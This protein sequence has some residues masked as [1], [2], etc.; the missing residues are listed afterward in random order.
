MSKSWKCPRCSTANDTSSITCTSCGLLQGSVFVPS[1]LDD[2][3]IPASTTSDPGAAFLGEAW[4]S[5]TVPPAGDDAGMA[6]VPLPDAG[7]PASPPAARVPI[8]RRIPIGGIIF[9]VLVFGGGISNLLFGA[10]RADNGEIAKPGD[11]TVGDLRVGD[12]FDL[13]DPAAEAIE[14]VVARPC[15]QEH[16]Y[17]MFYTGSMAEGTYPPDSVF[18][19]FMTDN[20][21]PAFLAYIGKE[22]E[23]SKL[24]VYWLS[25]SGEGW[26]K[27]DRSIQCA[28]HDSQLSR[29]TESLKGAKR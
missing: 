24:D 17:E 9:L 27:G 28:V 1:A 23:A 6:P 11:L 19:V 4:R 26:G 2:H 5:G 29:L 21:M 18:E 16:E 7:T 8:W 14:K 25:P 3:P 22:Y 20:C 15:T 10:G 12:C 13:Q